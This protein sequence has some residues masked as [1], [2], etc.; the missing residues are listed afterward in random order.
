MARS[1]NTRLIDCPKNTWTRVARGSFHNVGSTYALTARDS[2]FNWRLRSS[3]P[4]FQ[5]QGQ[6]GIDVEERITVGSNLFWRLDVYPYENTTI[7]V[8]VV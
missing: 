1:R 8:R 7:Q 2:S 4:P 3:S 5:Q 6:V